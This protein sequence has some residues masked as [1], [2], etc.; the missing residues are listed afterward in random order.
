MLISKN[1]ICFSV[2]RISRGEMFDQNNDQDDADDDDDD[3][4]DANAEASRT[5][6]GLASEFYF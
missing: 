2:L 4:T 6:G 1:R 3:D 5:D